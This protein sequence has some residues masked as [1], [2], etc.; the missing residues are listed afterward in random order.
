M[1]LKK[2]VLFLL[3][4][5]FSFLGGAEV[6]TLL[7]L[8]GHLD[9]GEIQKA[10]ADLEK[11][12]QGPLILEINSTSGDVQQVLSLAKRIYELKQ[13]RKL[14]VIVYIEDNAIGP[15]A[16]LPFLNDELYI[17]LFVSWGDIPLGSETVLP[18]N[19]LRNRVISLISLTHPQARI[20]NLLATAMCDKTVKVVKVGREWRLAGASVDGAEVISS[21]ETLVVNQNQ[22]EELNL[23]RGMLPLERFKVRFNLAQKEAP[24]FTPEGE[25]ATLLN[26]N[27]EKELQEYIHFNEQDPNTVGLISITS[28]IT[29]GT[30]I[31]VKN[32][33][34]YY[35]KTKP[36]FIILE[37]NTPG[38]EVFA[39]Q[40]ISDALKDLDIQ[41]NIP[42]VAYI[43]NWA[44]SAGAMLA[45]SCRFITVVKDGAMGAAEPLTV[46]GEKTEIASEKVNSALRADFANRANFFGRNSSIAEAMVDKDII[47][48]QRHGQIVK[49]DSE[50]QIRK[51]GPDPDL[52]ISPK[53]KLLTLS[54]DLLI[55]YGVVDL[56]LLPKKLEPITE[57]EKETGKWPAAKL[58]L[59]SHPFF[60]KIPEAFIDVFKMDLKL[61]FLVLLANP[62][63]QSV[64]FLGLMIGLYMEFS[65][66]GFGLPGTVAITCLFLIL[67]SSYA[68]EI[69]NWLEVILLLTGILIILVELFILPT[70]GLLGF[71]GIVFFLA[72]LFGLMLPGLSSINYELDTQTFN[73]AGEAFFERLAWLSG[74]LILGSIIILL[75]TRY[76]TP[77]FAGFR[78]FV[79]S[80]NEQNGFISGAS[81]HDLPIPGTVGEAFTPLRPA[82]KVIFN[83]IIY[84][85]ISSGT[86]IE[87]GATVAV[88]RLDG[89]VIVVKIYQV[90]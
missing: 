18:V 5:F 10:I 30:W 13:E 3:F 23:I 83:D 59:F 82:G 52:L 50:D 58:L 61:Q 32:A 6:G 46:S 87:K 85:A 55:K 21:G 67:L 72:G 39:A 35:K 78:R 8:K 88:E 74:S 90:E 37:L 25:K 76:M 64:L 69:A 11:I 86:F 49:L 44:I 41:F 4:S 56:M 16:I 29:Q 84:D 33:L 17:S 73:A 63:V 24:T 71:I 14:S 89:S 26:K 31:Y 38:G 28:E 20:L 60:A 75:L 81:A 40:K 1:H 34:D 2:I 51:T 36:S 66:P 62:A 70:F 22:L 79:L 53:G 48:V 47:L 42:V 7:S 57:K 19:L 54:A 65:S 68:L 27:V 43:N 77:T 45:Y 9:K 80:G 12:E 15:A